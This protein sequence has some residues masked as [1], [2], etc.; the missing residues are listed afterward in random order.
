MNL[1]HRYRKLSAYAALTLAALLSGPEALAWDQMPGPLWP[2]GN[3]EMHLHLG[4]DMIYSDG[5]TPNDVA[6]AA[7]QV[8]NPLVQRVQFVPRTGVVVSQGL[9]NG[10]NNVTF[11]RTL[12]GMEWGEGTLAVAICD[13]D[14][15]RRTE[16][17][18]IVNANYAW[19]RY[20]TASSNEPFD[21]KRVLVHEF[22]HLLNLDH[23]DEV[24]QIVDAIMNSRVSHIAGPQ[25]DDLDG[26]GALYGYTPTN[27]GRPPV[28]DFTP[29][30]ITVEAGLPLYLSASSVIGA[31]PMS[32]QWFKDGAPLAGQTNIELIIDPAAMADAGNYHVVIT[33][34]AGSL[35]SPPYPVAVVEPIAPAIN[36][37]T[38]NLTMERV[39]GGD[40]LTGDLSLYVHVL[41]SPPFTFQWYRNGLPIPGATEQ[42][43][44]VARVTDA[45]EGDYHVVVSNHA[46]SSSSPLF[47]VR[48]VPLPLPYAPKSHYSI[49]APGTMVLIK[50]SEE[51]LR[52][53]WLGGKELYFNGAKIADSSTSTLSIVYPDSAPGE[54]LVVSRNASG[55]SSSFGYWLVYDANTPPNA[56]PVPAIDPSNRDLRVDRVMLDRQGNL[57]LFS[58]FHRHLWIWSLAESRFIATVPL[59]G[60]ANAAIYHPLWDRVLLAYADGR[61]TQIDPQNPSAPETVFAQVT[62]AGADLEPVDD[63]LLV[64]TR[65]SYLHTLSIY[66]ADGSVS[67]SRSGVHQA[68][69]VV[70]NSARRRLYLA[71]GFLIDAIPVDASGKLGS[72]Q[73]LTYEISPNDNGFRAD[74]PLILSADGNQLLSG[75]GSVFDAV[76]LQNLHTLPDR[77]EAAVWTRN[78]IYR[79]TTTTRGILVSRIN[80]KT[81]AQEK[82]AYIP[83]HS[84]RMFEAP[85]N[86]LIVTSVSN[87]RF[88]ISRFDRELRPLSRLSHN[89][90]DLLGARAQLSNLSTRVFLPDEGSGVLTA[91]FVIGGTEPLPVLLRAIG[92]GLGA[93]NITNFLGDPAI[94]LF[95]AQGTAIASNDGWRDGSS[96][97][98]NDLVE[99]FNQLGAFLPDAG[100]RDSALS[101]TLPPG[102][103]T[104]QVARGN[105]PGGVVLVE[106]YDATRGT[107]N[108]HLVNLSTRMDTGT[109]ERIL[110]TGFV[111]VGDNTRQVLVRA[112]GPSLSRFGVTGVLTDPLL[113][114]YRNSTLVGQNDDWA[115]STPVK[116]A[117]QSAGAFPF[118]SETSLD[119]ATLTELNPGAYTNQVLTKDGTTGNVLIEVY[120]V[121]N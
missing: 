75:T 86:E 66:R 61:I 107:S 119:A 118:V 109:G 35:T 4:E 16:G 52:R 73:I 42:G 15:T 36:S 113:Q 65:G 103:Y 56:T 28:F 68:Q 69:D 32:F 1:V 44:G 50:Q 41:G 70:W 102:A 26:V 63:L 94:T 100:S 14:Q 55:Q 92:P 18:V 10:V 19:D 117:M 80:S 47:T 62:E 72:D 105:Q 78:G 53:A 74:P 59:F 13:Y 46:G 91:G 87:D 34:P 40:S 11:G 51:A 108:S 58:R 82:Q 76:N 71:G 99:L 12:Y 96:N 95:N 27:P 49:N 45:D 43:Y 88:I 116:L 39:A 30:A 104:A 21:L 84:P 79:S 85:G 31:G 111:L 93:F 17:D 64:R 110:T 23:P 112:A 22:G 2:D 101:I 29:P 106:V 5:S 60:Y 33:N 57:I 48:V 20:D 114:I 24:G 120:R 67:H 97:D 38:R 90:E 37:P 54:Y 3:I 115:G 8:W 121:D 9:G 77:H 25:A 7:L 83:G 81:F 98:G 89:G 6:R